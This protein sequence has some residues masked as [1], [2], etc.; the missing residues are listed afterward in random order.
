MLGALN[1]QRAELLIHTL[2]AQGVSY[3]CLAPGSRS[4]PLMLAV[5]ALPSSQWCIHFDERGL[6]FHA[7]GIAKGRKSPVAVIV[8]S[9]TA[10]ANL[11]P[12]V[13]EAFAS[14][15]PL[16]LLSADRPPEL[17]D[18][19][20]N[21]TIDQIKIFGSFVHFYCDLP[22]SDSL[23][24]HSYLASTLALA[25]RHAKKGPVHINC[26]I[27]E[28]FFANTPTPPPAALGPY[29]EKSQ[30][31]P[32]EESLIRWAQKL[33]TKTSGVILLGS[34]AIA[35]AYQGILSLAEHLGWPIFSDILSGGRQLPPH[36]LH[37]PYHTLFLQNSPDL[38]VEA[39]LHLGNRFTSKTLSHWLS[40]QTQAE[41]FQVLHHDSR[42]DPLLQVSYHIECEENSFACALLPYLPPPRT[43]PWAWI[44]KSCIIQQAVNDYFSTQKAFSALSILHSLQNQN[45]VFLS[46]SMTIR[47]ADLLLYPPQG[48]I[49]AEANRGASGID[50]N[51]AT[52]IGLAQGLGK[53]IV[54]IVGDLATLH[55][56]NSLALAKNASVLFVIINNQGGGIFSF[57]PIQ[58]KTEIFETC[59][60]TAHS[61]DFANA[62]SLFHI[63]YFSADSQASWQQ[64]WEK[65][66]FPAHSCIIE[67]KLS[68][69]E[70]VFHHQHFYSYIQEALCSSIKP[71]PTAALNQ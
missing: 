20:A 59:V 48:P 62:A 50:G 8:T 30:L 1:T 4:T 52:A 14:R 61:Y 25:A 60:A 57:L 44:Q 65:A 37:I 19:G 45:T 3:F 39:I 2:I 31:I 64:A 36:P 32:S 58:E 43:Y 51:I 46:N 10:V 67:C 18:C 23:C 6:G 28:P 34:E 26:M 35:G 55:D 29:Y 66:P 54:A 69:Q 17:R 71:L 13:A 9:G 5:T 22:L 56:L 70:E 27:R 15:V 40:Q 7:L 33:S 47:N 21:Q 16:I 63:P 41:Y 68:R 38:Q 42:Q 11:F 12:A 49:Q 53:P 24:P